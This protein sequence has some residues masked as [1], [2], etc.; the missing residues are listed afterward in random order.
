VPSGAIA[1]SSPAVVESAELQSTVFDGAR[2]H[3]DLL[4]IMSLRSL[5]GCCELP[6][7]HGSLVETRP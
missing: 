2:A 1:P 7:L 4:L 3:S 5:E 6:A